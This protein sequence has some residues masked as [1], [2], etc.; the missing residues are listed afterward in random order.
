LQKLVDLQFVVPH[1]PGE[2]LA[3]YYGASEWDPQ[4]KKLTVGLVQEG[5]LC[6]VQTDIDAG[7]R[8]DLAR[9]ISTEKMYEHYTWGWALVHFL[10]NDS[11]YASKFQHF[12]LALPDAKGVQRQEAAQGM[13]TL[14]QG[15]VFTIFSREMGLKDAVA[16]RKLQAEW[17]DYVDGKL[18]L[19]TCSG[20]EKA[21]FK[22]KEVGRTKRATRLFRTAIE[23]GSKNPLVY[24]NLAEIYA[25][26]GNRDDAFATWKQAIAI[27]PLEGT[28]YSRMAFFMEDTD[29]AEAERLRKLA[30]EIGHD[31]PWEYVTLGEEHPD[32]EKPGKPGEKPKD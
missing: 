10:M 28:L 17:D 1:F 19:V 29:K 11:R 22:A 27:D 15:D 30:K 23:K 16:V 3:E 8:M 13:Y 12:F 24:H 32:P 9:L 6:E 21:G 31:D 5:R 7:N 4:K 26:E 18:K 25:R 2:S 14:K 20:Y